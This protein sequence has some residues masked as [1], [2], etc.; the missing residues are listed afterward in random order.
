MTQIVIIAYK[1][2]QDKEEILV[3]LIN[4]HWAILRQE[5]LVTERKPTIMVAN[6]GTIVEVFEWLSEKAV[7]DAHHNSKVLEM[8]KDFFEV[9]DVLPLNKLEESASYFA[10]FKPF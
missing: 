1:P 10:T 9:C 7:Q 4:S 5:G 2:K 6:N 3:K 8:W